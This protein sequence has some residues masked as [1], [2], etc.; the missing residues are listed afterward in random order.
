MCWS[1]RDQLRQSKLS[2]DRFWSFVA[3]ACVEILFSYV[4]TE[5]YKNNK[6]KRN[7][8]WHPDGRR[9]CSSLI[10]S[11][12]D[13]Q[14]TSAVALIICLRHYHYHHHHHYYHQ[15]KKIGDERDDCKE[16]EELNLTNCWCSGWD[17]LLHLVESSRWKIFVKRGRSEK[18][19]AITT[20]TTNGF[21][22]TR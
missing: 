10:S 3:K 2:N 6:E 21:I 20:A 9:Y 17:E 5:I 12:P 8:R 4:H 15:E 11:T 16:V 14:L 13:H 18:R 1:I 19:L 22:R 7:E